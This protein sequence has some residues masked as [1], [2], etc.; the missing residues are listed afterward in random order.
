MEP[1]IFTKIWNEEV[2][3]QVIEKTDKFI[4]ILDNS[5]WTKGHTLIIPKIQVESLL[6]L[7]PPYAKEMMIFAQEIADLLREK[8]KCPSFNF[9]IN[10]GEYAGQEVPHVHLHIIPRYNKKEILIEHKE[11][12]DSLDKIMSILKY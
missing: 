6:D 11:H 2:E 5:P 12:N 9:I 8:L 1:S 4:A 3:A 10:D 7:P